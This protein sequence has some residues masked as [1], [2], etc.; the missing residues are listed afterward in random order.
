MTSNPRILRQLGHILCSYTYKE[1]LIDKTKKNKDLL[2]SGFTL[3]TSI[4]I[5]HRM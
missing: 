2:Q 4:N 3:R 5:R 1:H